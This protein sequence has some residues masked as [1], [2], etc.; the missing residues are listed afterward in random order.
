[1]VS[2]EGET[3]PLKISYVGQEVEDWFKGIESMMTN[4][5]K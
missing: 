3:V 4:A 2:A 5:L 1:M